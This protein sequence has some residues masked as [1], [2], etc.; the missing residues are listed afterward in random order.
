MTIQPS[1]FKYEE[2][3]LYAD[4][5][6]EMAPIGVSEYTLASGVQQNAP[7]ICTASGFETTT[8]PEPW[9]QVS[10][11]GKY[12]KMGYG[13]FDTLDDGT[14]DTSVNQFAL[15]PDSSGKV[16]FNQTL[17]ENV[18]IEYEA[19]AS[20]S[21][22]MDSVNYNPIMDEIDSG[23]IHF[24]K[25]T[26][27]TS[28]YLISSQP[29]LLADGFQRSRLTAT[30]FDEDFDR[31]PEKEIVFEIQNMNGPY[32]ELGYLEPT[33]GTVIAVDPSGN[34]IRVQETTNRR[35]EARARYVA[36]IRQTGIQTIKAYLLDASG[37][38]DTARILQYYVI[39]G[40]FI[41]D[42]SMLDTLDY[43]T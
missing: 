1:G 30:I 8:P 34:S 36:A 39:S 32:S 5:A 31:V 19:G 18:F 40:P 13:Y 41:L 14:W 35:G 37:I 11:S 29:I 2:F 38:Y 12:Q 23:F 7:V 24:S 26:D 42:F 21:Y 4:K 28:L 43:L 17:L 9:G 10:G 27:P 20:G 16:V 3:Y 22:I 25:I 15:H 33:D 6:W